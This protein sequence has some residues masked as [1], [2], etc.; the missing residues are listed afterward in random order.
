MKLSEKILFL[1]KQN[2][3]SQEE[4][5]NKLG[6][7]RQAI[8]KWENA[9][10][11]PEIEKIRVLSDLFSVTFN[12]LLNDNIDLSNPTIVSTNNE[13]TGEAQAPTPEPPEPTPEPPK[14]SKLP[15]I[16]SL[17]VA[18]LCAV[19]VIVIGVC[20]IVFSDKGH[21]HSFGEYTIISE[22]SCTKAGAQKRV[23][24]DCG[25]EETKNIPMVPHSKI[26]I[27][28]REP[29]C[30]SVGYTEG[31]KCS[32]CQTILKEPVEIAIVASNHSEQ[33]V[34]GTLPTCTK[35]GLTDGIKCQL[36]DAILKEQTVIPISKDN[37]ISETIKGYDATCVDDGLTDGIKCSE[38]NNVL[39]AQETIPAKGHTEVVVQG[40][41]PTCNSVGYKNGLQCSV[42]GTVTLE[43]EEIPI[44]PNAHEIEILPRVEPTC[45]TDGLT[46]GE[47]CSICKKTLTPQEIIP[48]NGTHTPVTLAGKDATCTEAGLTEGEICSVCDEILV[49]Q[50]EIPAT[51]HKEITLASKDATCTESGLTEG[52]QCSVCEEILVEQEE[53]LATGH[54]EIIL[55]SKDAT[56]TEAGL[57]EGKQCSVCE[58]ILLSQEIVPIKLHIIENDECTLCGLSADPSLFTFTLNDDG[59]SYTVAYEE[60]SAPISDI[61][62]P[63]KYGEYPVTGVGRFYGN[64]S[65]KRIFLPD[66]ITTIGDCAFWSVNISV[67]YVNIP[68]GV[69]SIGTN[70]FAGAN[71]ETIVVPKGATV[72]DGAFGSASLKSIV[73]EEGTTKIN[74]MAVSNSFT[75]LKHE[76]SIYIPYT[77]TTIEGP[78]LASVPDGDYVT[79][80]CENGADTSTWAE[81]WN[82]F[83]GDN[84]IGW[85]D[86]NVVWVDSVAV[87]NFIFELNEDNTSYS[88]KGVNGIEGEVKI[89]PTYNGLPVTNILKDGFRQ[90]SG[91]TA[92]YLPSSIKTISDG[93]FAECSNLSSITFNEGLEKISQYAFSGTA[94]TEVHIP[95]GVTHLGEEAFSF[96]KSLKAAYVPNT[97]I[98]MESTVFWECSLLEAIY[99]EN[100]ANLQEWWHHWDDLNWNNGYDN[101]TKHNVVWV[102]EGENIHSFRFVL[103]E[104]N[105]SYSVG[106]QICFDKVVI[107]STY[108]GLPVTA[109]LIE[110][111]KGQD[112][113]T[114]V[115]IPGSVKTI[116]MD[117]FSYCTSLTKVVLEE[118]VESLGTCV[119]EYCDN[120][121]SIY[122]PKTVTQIDSPLIITN[123]LDIGTTLYCQRGADTSNW[124]SDNSVE[125]WDKYMYAPALE[126][127]DLYK[128]LNVVWVDACPE[129]LL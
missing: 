93:A 71:L 43:L 47:K 60:G 10:T 117:A 94:I 54:K 22:P 25:E 104:D 109:I 29:T 4:L 26:T 1:R 52:K 27:E 102:G 62:V 120:I 118:G 74:P 72:S 66:T 23:C 103:N 48:S 14:K 45:I 73:Y 8:Y 2:G 86:Y 69:T 32:V 31:E 42:C 70:A 5:A 101:P 79:V 38:C 16:I 76:F 55:A 91:I 100:G 125:H 7:S 88:V 77:V 119:F 57:T 92:L 3:M 15:L 82:K 75:P 33:V 111:F 58:E 44:D 17:S 114:E 13:A 116:E 84:P 127:S 59:Q 95:S 46:E 90:M 110:G 80:Y 128:E 97:V 19:A 21:E 36:C 87:S 30:V 40:Y 51:G 129:S 89:P 108:K 35:T 112:K 106:G 63:S 126:L 18:F 34:Q 12:D 122:I 124:A 61:I 64:T 113:I 99:C 65:P 6:V 123:S 121:D 9:I 49:K 85:H 37:H 83:Y 56:C 50:E 24:K 78:V 115:Y 98:T 39:Q 67:D 107:P 41:K 96:C 20:L 11:S 81:N 105:A 28:R 68:S 53:I